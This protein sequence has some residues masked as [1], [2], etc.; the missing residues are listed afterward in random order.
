[1]IIGF[2][3]R[4]YFIDKV[5]VG[6]LMNYAEWGQEIFVRGTNNYYYSDK[7]Y[8][9]TPVYPPISIFTFAGAYWLNEHRYI[10]AQLHNITK[11]PPADFIIYFYQNGYIFL[12]KLLPIICD[13][14]LS[15][16]VYKLIF[17]LTKS[18]KKSFLGLIFFVLNP[19]SIFISGAW[20]QTDSI[21][22]ILGI[23]SFLLL[24]DKKIAFSIPLLF[25]SLYFKPSWAIFVPFYLFLVYKTKPNFK[26]FVLGSLAAL[27][28]FVVTTAPF[29]DTNVFAYGWKLFREKYPLP[30]GIDGKASISAFNFQTIFLRLD[31]D[32]SHE[33]IM[34]VRSSFLGTI[35]YLIINYLAFKNF[36]KQKNKL[37]GM[38]SGIFMIGFGSF[39][40]MATMLERYF[41]PAFVPMTVIM[42]SGINVFLEIV[43]INL[44]LAANIIYSFYRRGSDEIAHPFIDNNFLLIRVLSLV[45]VSVFVSA[46]VK[47]FKNNQT[48]K[49]Y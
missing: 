33:K 45:Q 36:N 11:I 23:Y 26:H 8:Y 38:L 30:I 47:I 17:K 7:W 18:Y 46:V 5:V 31:I 29:S 49:K 4:A 42:F 2:L 37:F 15:V 12:L 48:F 40:F 10:L 27:T 25:T 41:F 1:M 34:G 16:L 35:F 39:L 13:L 32:Y 22:G 43:L 3:V 21:V 24:L 20:G 19:I 28:I 44:I 9:S 14:L 6:D